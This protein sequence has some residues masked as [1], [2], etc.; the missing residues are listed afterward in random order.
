MEFVGII[1]VLVLGVVLLIGILSFLLTFR[2]RRSGISK[3]YAEQIVLRRYPAGRVIGARFLREGSK[4]YWE[5]DIYDQELIN[6][7]SVDAR[8]SVI[9]RVRSVAGK[10]YAS[11]S[12]RMYGQRAPGGT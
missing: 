6:R 7:V 9:A 5:L 2:F 8:S 10:P 4:W 11:A 12:T 3:D 1:F